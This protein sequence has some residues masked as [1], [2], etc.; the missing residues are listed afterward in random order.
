VQRTLS[1]RRAF[2]LI[3]LVAVLLVLAILGGIA[4]PRYINNAQRAKDSA[5][6][7]ALAGMSAALNSTYMSNRSTDADSSKWITTIA[8]IAPAMETKALPQGWTVDSNQL[9]DLRGNRYDF[10][11]ETAQSAAR[12]VSTT[13]GS[14]GGSGGAGGS[15]GTGGSGG[16]GVAARTASAVQAMSTAQVLASN[17]TPAE[18]ALLTPEQLAALSPAELAAFS[19]DHIAALTASQ[20]TGLTYAQVESISPRVTATQIP[21]LR[22]DQLAM[23]SASAWAALTPAQRAAMTADQV[24]ERAISEEARTRN[25]DAIRTLNVAAIK[26]LLPT[27]IAAINSDYQMGLLSADRRAALTQDQVQAINARNVSLAYLTDA[28]RLQLTADQFGVIR[29]DDVRYVPVARLNDVPAGTIGAINSDYAMGLISENR[30]AAF[31]TAQVQALN[32]AVV[33]LAYLTDAQRAQTTVAQLAAIRTDDVR[34]AP[35]SRLA[36]VLPTTIGAINSD[37]AMG[38][39]SA[40]RRA[41]FNTAQVQALN[42]A[43]VSLAY[44]TDAQRAQT[45]STQLAAIRT[46]DVRYVPVSRLADV[47]AGTIGAI[48]SDYAMGLISED[49]RAAFNTA[50]VQAL[51][52]AVVS[53][54][55]LTDTQ[56]EQATSAQL[57]NIRTD[58]VRYVPVSRLADVPAATVARINSDY[59]MGL[60]SADRRAAFN[61]AQIQALNTSVVSLAYLTDAQRALATSAQLA[62]IRTDDVR[63]VPP[64]RMGD[65]TTGAVG[66]INSDYAMG[67]V[68]ADRRAAFNT[69]QVQALNTA[70]VSLAY[71]TD[72]QRE[73]TTSAQL[74][75]IR[76]SDVQHAP[77]SRMGE[78]PTATIAAISSDY[79]WGLVSTPRVQALTQA[80]ILAIPAARYNVLRSRLTAQQQAWR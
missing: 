71:L 70:V 72:A 43:V 73:Q 9:I 63:Y 65:V 16:S 11:P 6:E 46:D 54:V 55:Y 10:I 45:T 12:I 50:Q 2:T 5:D 76:T 19:D 29:T 20:L 24:A 30:R 18:F 15:G 79:E 31:N 14:P 33:S 69:A 25:F 17:L 44:L 27:Q 56:R 53:L 23:L 59:A 48:N 57:A 67:L 77:A 51:N 78:I 34:Y 3:E 36:D 21:L 26:Y 62:N 35:V 28:Q 13:A 38:L 66:G 75:A 41:A 22:P 60:I 37:Y 47:P 7:G 52:T 8:A 1:V 64:T 40:D 74:A 32:T 61:T 58:D 80:Q 42:T 39:I 68:S 4:I 49:R